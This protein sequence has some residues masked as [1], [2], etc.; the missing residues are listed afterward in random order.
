MNP[1]AIVKTVSHDKSFDVIKDTVD[2]AVNFVKPTYGYGGKKVIISKQMYKMVVDDGVQ[3]MRDYEF[4]DKNKQAVFEVIR[5]T[6]IKTNDRVGDGTTSSMLMLQAIINEASSK[7]VKRDGHKIEAELKA[8]FDEF[9]K[10]ILKKVKKVTTKTELE[11]VARI[12]F[13]D[14][15]ISKII[16]D[17]MWDVG[18]DGVIGIEKSPTMETTYERTNGLEIKSGVISRYFISDTQRNETEMEN[19]LVLVTDYR[20]TNVGDVLPIMEKMLKAGKTELIIFA[21]NVEGAALNTLVVNRLQGKFNAIAVAVSGD[22]RKEILEN[23]ALVTGASIYS[24]D[25]GS[26]VDFA[27]LKDLGKCIRVSAKLDKTLIFGVKSQKPEVAKFVTELKAASL[28][29]K[30]PEEKDRMLKRAAELSDGIAIIKVGAPT[31]NAAKALKYKVED[32]VNA[33]K[34]AYRGGVVC[35]AGLALASI[36]TSSPILN[37]ALQ[38]PARQAKEN[39]DMEEVVL[40]HDEAYDAA[41]GQ[42]GNYL[43]LGI[44]DPVEVLI[45]GVESAISI[46][47]LLM[48]SSGVIYEVDKPVK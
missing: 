35:G 6:A 3:V 2:E 16:G 13:N 24:E 30:S 45:A 5:E 29:A 7:N 1:N 10:Q 19:P 25:K 44:I 20:L 32:A 26:K 33:V 15:K 37:K 41:T 18:V 28:L 38:Y 39:S 23:I 47:S 9:K 21:E 43:K 48:T 42:V 36:K 14:P 8:G 31:D 27:E 46:A 4:E 12:S 22:R 34:V 11:Q 40:G 17:L